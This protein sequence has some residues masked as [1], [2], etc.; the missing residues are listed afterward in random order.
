MCVYSG[1]PTLYNILSL[2]L[3]TLREEMNND[4][5]MSDDD[6]SFSSNN[7]D[8][9]A[10]KLSPELTNS[11]SS[12][13]S[14]QDG[15]RK[16]KRANPI[17]LPSVPDDSNDEFCCYDDGTVVSNENEDRD[18]TNGSGSS[19]K[20]FKAENQS[21]DGESVAERAG[22]VSPTKESHDAQGKKSSD[23]VEMKAAAAIAAAAATLEKERK[24]SALDLA[25]NLS[26][27]SKNSHDELVD[28]DKQKITTNGNHAEGDDHPSG[29]NSEE[30]E[31]EIREDKLGG[32]EVRSETGSPRR[33]DGGE[34][35]HLD[36]LKNLPIFNSSSQPQVGHESDSSD[37]CKS[38][39]EETGRSI[40][41]PNSTS[42]LAFPFI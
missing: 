27:S 40:G 2:Y 25:L 5:Y 29:L 42:K 31:E 38:D 34:T 18:S 28:E 24:N 11:S 22:S 19:P 37:M 4:D 12:S 26:P 41:S 15:A 33:G 14:K 30:D 39:D 21:E 10:Q 1:Q 20:R 17:R 6:G 9:S 16:R 23:E 3:E 36:R 8:S 13:L 35:D 7:E 32:E